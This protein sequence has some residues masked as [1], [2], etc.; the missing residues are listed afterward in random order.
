[1]CYSSLFSHL[2]GSLS[3]NTSVFSPLPKPEVSTSQAEIDLDETIP[4]INAT[5]RT[6]SSRAPVGVRCWE[7]NWAADALYALGEV[8]KKDDLKGKNIYDVAGRFCYQTNG[9]KISANDATIGKH[10]WFR[11]VFKTS[12][13]PFVPVTTRI[14]NAVK[15]RGTV[16]GKVC[17][18]AMVEIISKCTAPGKPSKLNYFRGGQYTAANGWVYAIVCE[19]KY[20]LF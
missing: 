11:N 1:M 6:L 14:V 5:E 13:L 3:S 17:T 19:K 2:F 10:Y 15:V 8:D 9:H 20:C 18:D 12:P 4:F 16:S 7:L